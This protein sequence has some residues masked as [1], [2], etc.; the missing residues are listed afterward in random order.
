MAL[1]TSAVTLTIGTTAESLLNGGNVTGGGMFPRGVILCQKTSDSGTIHIRHDGTAT[2]AY[3][4][5]P[6]TAIESGGLP[7]SWQAI[8]K[9][10]VSVIGSA[11]GQT[12]YVYPF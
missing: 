10:L 2:T 7:I 11:A 8:E 5:L 6:K 9:G 3:P 12:L 1:I 4:P